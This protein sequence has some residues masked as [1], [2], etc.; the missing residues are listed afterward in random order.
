MRFLPAITGEIKISV[1]LHTQR[2][3]NTHG[4]VAPAN[5]TGIELKVKAGSF[6][7]RNVRKKPSNTLTP[8]A[9]GGGNLH[10]A[11]RADLRPALRFLLGH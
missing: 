5:S 8:P 9:T 3:M 7:T 11:F 10:R 4:I 1:L 2:K 6:R